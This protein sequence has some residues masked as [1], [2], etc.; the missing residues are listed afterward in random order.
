MVYT[1]LEAG[2]KEVYNYQGQEAAHAFVNL[3]REA[4]LALNISLDLE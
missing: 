4:A 2:L 1:M 3:V